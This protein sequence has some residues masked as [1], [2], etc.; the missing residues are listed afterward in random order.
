MV[1]NSSTR[2]RWYPLS[3]RGGPCAETLGYGGLPVAEGRSGPVPKAR[4]DLDQ[5]SARA[6]KEVLAP[7]S[8]AGVAY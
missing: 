3:T 6:R 8:G 5:A 1:P 7:S 4:D 2:T